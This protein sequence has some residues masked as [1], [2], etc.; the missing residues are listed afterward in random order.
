LLVQ[1]ASFN[2]VSGVA[3]REQRGGP[4]HGSTRQPKGRHG[5]RPNVVW[6]GPIAEGEARLRPSKSS[7]WKDW[8]G[9]CCGLIWS[10]VQGSTWYLVCAMF[11]I[12]IYDLDFFVL[13]GRGWGVCALC[14]IEFGSPCIGSSL[15]DRSWFVIWC[16]PSYLWL[17]SWELDAFIEDL[18]WIWLYCVLDWSRQGWEGC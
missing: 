11:L 7:E 5:R 8:I 17:S 18:T 14:M 9:F 6:A 4:G 12:T 10:K 2:L 15:F 16:I 1:T 13:S 3:G